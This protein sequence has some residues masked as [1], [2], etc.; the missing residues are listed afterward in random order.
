MSLLSTGKKQAG[1]SPAYLTKPL[2]HNKVVL[3]VVRELVWSTV[4]THQITVSDE[5]FE[6]LRSLAEPFVDR[7]PEDVLRRLL[8]R[9]VPVLGRDNAQP[10]FEAQI[11]ESPR[12]GLSP[13]SRV[14]RERGT[15]VQIGDNKID[16]VSV[17]ALYDEALKLF[18]QKHSSKLK[19]VVPFKTSGQRYLIAVRPVH[20][21]GKAFVV[22]VEFHGFYMEAHKDYKNGIEHLRRLCNRLGLSLKYLG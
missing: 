2:N 10:E 5:V 18:V 19:S 7:E 12:G 1:A 4:M 14:P 8:D 17:R 22:P 20:P 16:A 9:N 13:I 11:P 15:T 6:R 21:S 3:V